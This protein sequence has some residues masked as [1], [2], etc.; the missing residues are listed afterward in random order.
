MVGVA[1]V[2]FFAQHLVSQR[3]VAG[4]GVQPAHDLTTA[5]S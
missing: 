5:H 4:H 2:Q 1:E 3:A